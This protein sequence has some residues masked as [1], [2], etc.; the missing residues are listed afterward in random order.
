MYY[1]IQKNIMRFVTF[2]KTLRT[3]KIQ[4]NGKYIPVAI[5]ELYFK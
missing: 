5:S 4:K 3:I 2:I 1:I